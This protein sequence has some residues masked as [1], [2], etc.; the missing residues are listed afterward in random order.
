MLHVVETSQAVRRMVTRHA[1]AACER[2]GATVTYQF[3][4]V[5]AIKTVA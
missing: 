2:D 5:G 3:P 1:P 4:T